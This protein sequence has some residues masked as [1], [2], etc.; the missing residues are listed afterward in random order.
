MDLKKRIEWLETE[1]ERTKELAKAEKEKN[2]F[3]QNG[4][5]FYYIDSIL[6]VGED[7]FA[8]GTLDYTFQKAG[9]CFKTK[10]E[11]EFLVEKIKV[12]NEL[13]EYS[14]PF[15]YGKENYYL[16][17]QYDVYGEKSFV[18]ALWTSYEKTN[19]IF[20]ACKK[21]AEEAINAVGEDRIKKYYLGIK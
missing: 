20:F 4:D 6:A 1:L 5:K 9:N 16:V 15:I 12:I 21:K 13:K 10:E 8:S 2:E 18:R 3:P 7:V 17:W 14:R 11:A 19:N